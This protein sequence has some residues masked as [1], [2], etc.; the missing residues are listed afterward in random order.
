MRVEW[1]ELAAGLRQRAAALDAFIADVYG[2]REIVAAGRMPEWVIETA[3]HFE[4]SARR[5]GPVGAG[6]CS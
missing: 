5:T 2:E 6:R 4:P 1:Q 3:D